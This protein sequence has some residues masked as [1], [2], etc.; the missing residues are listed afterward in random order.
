[1]NRSDPDDVAKAIAALGVWSK[2]KPC[3]WAV[4]PKLS[5]QAFICLAAAAPKTE[6]AD[7]VAGRLLVFPGY[8]SFNLFA[9]REKMHD[10]GVATCV[11]ELEHWC[12]EARESGATQILQMVPGFVP[13]K[14]ELPK[15]RELLAAVMYECY[16]VML[17]CEEDPDLLLRHIQD[18]ALFARWQNADG[19]WRDGEYRVPVNAI[20]NYTEK[21]SMSKADIDKAKMLPMHDGERWLAEFSL[22][23]NMITN[24]REARFAY[25]FAVAKDDGELK[26]AAR[27]SVGSRIPGMPVADASEPLRILWEQLAQRLLNVFLEAG[28]V[29]GEVTVPSARLMRFLRPLAMQLP[30]RL[31]LR[32][33]A[34]EFRT[35]MH[36]AIET[37]KL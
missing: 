22:V 11:A 4:L 16:G 35:L 27:L 31:A 13:R 9:L 6:S 19:S 25:V 20:S 28:Y 24:E 37:F 1:M 7:P 5:E 30:F 18:K 14:P 36:N 21:I 3:Q 34:P 23:D 17:R 10:F 12:I 26:T 29:P 2:V 8:G 33:N 32:S 15:E